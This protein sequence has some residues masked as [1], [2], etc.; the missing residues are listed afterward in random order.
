MKDFVNRVRAFITFDYP[1]EIASISKQFTELHRQLQAETPGWSTVATKQKLISKYWNI[2]V[3]GHYALI[4]ILPI[5]VIIL[6][7][8]SIEKG[9]LLSIVMA[10]V[11]SFPILYLFHYRPSFGSFYL[12]RLETVKEMYERKALEQ[13]EKCRQSQLSN[14]AL[15]LIFYVLDKTSGINSLQCNDRFAALLTQLYGVDAGSLKKNLELII[16]KRQN[17]SARKVTEIQNRFGEAY[18]FFNELHFKEGV[19]ILI[20]L[21]SKFK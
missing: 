18:E 16:G 10:G 21:E 14:F 15:A 2:Y 13:L 8:G 19:R 7:K 12:P 6:F 11:V 17:L 9:Y 5:V 20:E 4:F 3:A 1:I